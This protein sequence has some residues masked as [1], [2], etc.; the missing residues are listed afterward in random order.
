MNS[1]A[2]FDDRVTEETLK[3]LKLCFLSGIFISESTLKAVENLVK[4]NG[5]TVV[6]P[7]RFAP[8]Y[9]LEKAGAK[10]N[11][12]TDGKGLWIVTD[13]IAGK[14]VKKRILPFIGNKNEIR[15]T[16]EK[17]E[18]IMKISPDGNAIQ[19]AGFKT[20]EIVKSEKTG[21]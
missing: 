2:V 13:D 3:S 17:R 20:D 15:L 1:T 19:P 5:L 14:K 10:Y 16:F 7:K 8:A 4:E 18:V 6:T 11:E 12:I 9:I 21:K